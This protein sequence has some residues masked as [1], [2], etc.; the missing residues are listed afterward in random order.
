MVKRSSLTAEGFERTKNI[1]KTKY[2]KESEIV[3]A[4]ISNIMALEP[5]HGTNP[6]KISIYYEKLLANV[7]ALVTLGPIAEVNGYV[8]LTLDKLESIRDLVRTDDGWLNWKVSQLI[9]ASRK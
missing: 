6:N 1:L 7:Q 2:G 4:Y 3:N 5:V 8:R 9:E